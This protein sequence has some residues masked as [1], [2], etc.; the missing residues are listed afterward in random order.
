MNEIYG[1]GFGLLFSLYFFLTSKRWTEEICSTD[2]LA[3]REM[4]PH[5][6]TRGDCE[7]GKK[8]E[9][10]HILN[11]FLFWTSLCVHKYAFLHLNHSNFT[12][13][14]LNSGTRSL[15]HT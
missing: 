4:N 11:D 9:I 1:F 12:K 5:E 10:L 15:D 7:Q 2:L 3:K 13:G 14:I 6:C 8:G